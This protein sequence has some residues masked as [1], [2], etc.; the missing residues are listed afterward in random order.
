MLGSAHPAHRAVALRRPATSAVLSAVLARAVLPPPP[1]PG[2][3]YPSAPRASAPDVPPPPRRATPLAQIDSRR[4][5]GDAYRALPRPRL[6]Q[7]GVIRE[8]WSLPAAW[9]TGSEGRWRGLVVGARSD[10]RGGG[11]G[12]RGSS[13]ADG[14]GESG[15]GGGEEKATTRR[16][17]RK[18]GEER[19]VDVGEQSAVRGTESAAGA[20]RSAVAEESSGGGVVEGEAEREGGGEGAARDQVLFPPPVVPAAFE[21]VQQWVLFSDLHV[22][23]RN[24]ELCAALL[25][26]VHG[27][28]KDRAAGVVFLGDFWH[29]RGSLPVE[30]L[31]AV[32]GVMGPHCWTQPTI[33]IPGNHDQVSMDG[34]QHALSVFACI[35]PHI[36]VISRPT[37]LLSALWL[38]FRHHAPILTAA[39]HQ[40]LHPQAPS[41]PSLPP[42]P[43]IRAIFLHA[44]VEGAQRSSAEGATT[45]PGEGLDPLALPPGVPLYSGHLHLPHTVNKGGR[46]VQYVGSCVQHS[47]GEAGQSKRAVVVRADSWERVEDIPLD[48]GPRHFI[49]PAPHLQQREGLSAAQAMEEAV[50]RVVPQ[51]RPDDLV[52]WEVPAGADAKDTREA[53]ASLRA[54]GALVQTIASQ[55]ITRPPR[56]LQADTLE[57]SRVFA[58]YATAAHLPSSVLSAAQDVLKELDVPPRLMHSTSAHVCLHSVH[59]S[60]F[61]PFLAPAFYPL[62]SRGIVLLCGRNDDS[63]GAAADSN[64]AGKTSL[65][66]AALWGL[67]GDMD[68]RPEGRGGLRMADVVHRGQGEGEGAGE[69]GG[70]GKAKGRRKKGEGNGGGVARVRVEGAVNGTPFVVEREASSRRSALRFEVGGED[71]TCQEMRLTQERI[72]ALMDTSLLSRTV[73]FGQHSTASLLEANDADFKAELS[74]V[75]GMEVWGGAKAASRERVRALQARLGEMRGGLQARTDAVTRLAR[76]VEEAEGAFSTWEEH[77]A[78]RQQ[79]LQ[80]QQQQAEQQLAAACQCLSSQ[81]SPRLQAAVA[82]SHS[83]ALALHSAVLASLAGGGREGE[84]GADERGEGGSTEARGAE[85]EEE[86]ELR[87]RGLMTEIACLQGELSAARAGLADQQ[88]RLGEFEAHVGGAVGG[89]Q[90]LVCDRCQQPI[91]PLHAAECSRQLRAEVE[92]TQQQLAARTEAQEALQAELVGVRGWVEARRRGRREREERDAQA[93][94]RQQQAAMA[95]QE[96]LRAV[97]RYTAAASQ[98]LDA[99]LLFLHRHAAH[100]PAPLPP[101]PASADAGAAES[102]GDAAWR[103]EEV[104]AVIREA[105]AALKGVE[106][107]EGEVERRRRE[108]ERERGEVNPHEGETRR[109]QQLLE[110]GRREVGAVEGEV[111][112]VEAQLAVMRH[113]DAAFGLAGVQSFVLEGALSELDAHVARYLCALS[114]G[115]L[116]LHLSPTRATATSSTAKGGRKKRTKKASGA[117]KN[118]A[119][120]SSTDSEASSM[121]ESEG[122]EGGAEEAG[123][124][125]GQTLE[126][127]DKSV[128]VHLASGELV[129]RALRQLSGGERRRVALALALAFAEVAAERSGVRWDLLVLDEV[130]QH[131]D[132]QG[133]AAVAAVLRSLPQRT[134]VVVSQANSRE[135]LAEFGA[136]DWV[137]KRRDAA[138]VELAHM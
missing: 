91:D 136:V 37:V 74:R 8:G 69:G 138:T 73:F 40:A 10:G 54:T 135:A 64:G 71:H 11:E 94:R 89:G 61:G 86:M 29:V 83:H 6:V 49:I 2:A 51:L 57:P 41:S 117:G 112:A 33:M 88:R 132:D 95:Q 84:G 93:R 34:S 120:D 32:M 99:L 5:G 103:Q 96:E 62:A 122:G 56:I 47:F 79:R 55:A 14:V 130:F 43:P 114:A 27:L 26:H 23:R 82:R 128:W 77:R 72:D 48:V 133:V 35:N 75:V 44:D 31:N 100:L 7:G 42:T 18:G 50:R 20:A 3:R 116:H 15:G 28:A 98:A 127:I 13:K 129:P 118:G 12:E 22:S 1:A 53:L 90:V 108:V 124:G 9:R 109:L 30:A 70:E 80:Q 76:M 105:G 101:P 126:R 45:L 78:I 67:T 115:A 113:V 137:V 4:A 131:L 19:V 81:L 85:E 92:E 102:D 111:H 65:A 134:V 38:P 104:A 107:T 36:V 24:A 25:K 16:G 125:A 63:S 119:G 121:S 60:G 46:A 106:E 110:E 21:R 59:L 66:M 68:A 58:S 123:S 17:R 52:R 39:M 87:E 97:Q